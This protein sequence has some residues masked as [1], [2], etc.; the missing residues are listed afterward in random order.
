MLQ[1]L[2]QLHP[3]GARLGATAAASSHLQLMR[4]S[5]ASRSKSAPAC[6]VAV[7]GACRLLL[8]TI[9]RRLRASRPAGAI[10]ETATVVI[11]TL[12]RYQVRAEAKAAMQPTEPTKLL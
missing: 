6:N 2:Q 10:Y 12:A 3:T 7:E 11:G 1:G 8:L 5:L 4:G 9:L